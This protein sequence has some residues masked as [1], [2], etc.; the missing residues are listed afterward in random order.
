M[1]GNDTNYNF[2]TENPINKL[3]ILRNTMITFRYSDLW[4]YTTDRK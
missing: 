4:M 3:L 1:E 2:A